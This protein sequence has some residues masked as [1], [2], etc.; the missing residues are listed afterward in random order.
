MPKST[1]VEPIN[2]DASS[3]GRETPSGDAPDVATAAL[4]QSPAEGNPPAALSHLLQ[5]WLS[6]AVALLRI[7]SEI[8]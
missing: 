4:T 3:L 1:C 5:D 2:S 8:K 7:S 6:N